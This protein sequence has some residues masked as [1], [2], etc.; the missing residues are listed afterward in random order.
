MIPDSLYKGGR[1]VMNMF[2]SKMTTLA[3]WGI[4]L[5][6]VLL[7]MGCG[8]SEK[9][10]RSA[11]QDLE[12]TRV[13]MEELTKENQTLK[14]EQGKF[15]EDN[16]KSLQDR[17]AALKTAEETAAE[18]KNLQDELKSRNK[19]IAALKNMGALSK[20]KKAEI[21]RLRALAGTLRTALREQMGK[22]GVRVDQ[23]MDKLSLIIPESVLFEEGDIE[24]T[25]EGEEALIKVGEI[26]R[27]VKDQQVRV[28]GHTDN[29]PLDPTLSSEFPTNWEFSVARA[30]SIVRFLEEHAGVDSKALS[31]AGYAM[32][33]PTASNDTEQGR[34]ENRRIEIVLLPWDADRL[35]KK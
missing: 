4:V 3:L 21:E 20:A 5:A 25:P 23:I 7:A 17:D 6:Q 26:L 15:K 31:I 9:E 11:I 19:E 14:T 28:E 16:A 32:N 34:A 33:R 13:R 1:T 18:V 29:F 10:Y 24:I 27:R 35:V 22:G 2:G 8:V 30:T 12:R